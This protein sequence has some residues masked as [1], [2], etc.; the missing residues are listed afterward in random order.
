LDVGRNRT[1]V[2]AL[3]PRLTSTWPPIIVRRQMTELQRVVDSL[4]R[5]LGR[6]VALFDPA[7]VLLAYSSHIDHVDDIRR[8]SILGRRAPAEGR[9]LVRQ[10]G[11]D[12]APGPVRLNYDDLGHDAR[13][14]APV[15][16]RGV[17]LGYVF[18]LEE[19]P[20]LTDADLH[21]VA[22]TA[23]LAGSVLYRHRLLHELERA[24]ERQVLR[25]LLTADESTRARAARTAVDKKMLR[26]GVPV[27]A[28]VVEPCAGNAKP[29]DDVRDALGAAMDRC[30]RMCAPGNS[31]H[32]VRADHAVF[33]VAAGDPVVALGDMTPFAARLL[34]QV[35]KEL[36]DLPGWSARV[37]IGTTVSEL[38]ELASS[39]AQARHAVRVAHSV[40]TMDHIVGWSD[41][42][43]YGMLANFPVDSSARELLPDAVRVLLDHTG[44]ADLLHTLETY[45]DH[46][47]SVNE[48]A[49]TL[50]LHRASL[51]YRLRR[52]EDVAGV[53]L[54]DGQVRLVLH[55]GLKLA[56]LAGMHPG[57]AS[58]GVR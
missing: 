4:G 22:E 58:E 24:S 16:C 49:Q 52:I 54:D 3:P 31:L 1:D 35:R 10:R 5:R 6:P 28:L 38:A 45:L 47:C 30:R 36:G 27:A 50:G 41:L 46:G 33:V 44:D 8:R 20:P 42:G 25:D 48:T 23:D 29:R 9:A 11:L 43:V 2:T 26:A 34:A 18:L 17:L 21:I 39:Y 40:S 56:R 15:R 7:L 32:L 19:Q 14:G 53:S 57:Q 37:G 12:T 55:L 51:Y 13:V